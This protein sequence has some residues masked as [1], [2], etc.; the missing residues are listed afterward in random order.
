[1]YIP[2]YD[3]RA[4]SGRVPFENLSG[5]RVKEDSDIPGSPDFRIN[6]AAFFYELRRRE[7]C[8]GAGR[9]GRGKQKHLL[10]Q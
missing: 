1:M 9:D 8:S 2:R 4:I 7:N 5:G 6:S 3:L 10:N